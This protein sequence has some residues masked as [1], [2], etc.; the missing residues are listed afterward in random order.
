MKKFRGSKEEESKEQPQWSFSRY[1]DTIGENLVPLAEEKKK[2]KPEVLKMQNPTPTRNTS[3]RKTGT[4]HL[5]ERKST[6]DADGDFMNI[7]PSD[8]SSHEQLENI[9]KLPTYQMDRSTNST[10]REPK[11]PDISFFKAWGLETSKKSD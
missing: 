5:V 1:R 2:E 3:L 9:N 8:E 6:D 4:E 11:T 10:G 7:L